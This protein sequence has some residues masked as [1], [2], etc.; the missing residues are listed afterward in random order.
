[1]RCANCKYYVNTWSICTCLVGEYAGAYSE[2]YNLCKEWTLNNP[3]RIVDADYLIGLLQDA[4]EVEDKLKRRREAE[5][6]RRVIK[7]IEDIC[8]DGN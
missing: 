2:P 7:V 1:M 8:V 3:K 5:A 6:Y 4:A